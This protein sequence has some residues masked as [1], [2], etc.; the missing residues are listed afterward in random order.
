MKER[1][2]KNDFIWIERSGE[3]EQRGGTGVGFNSGVRLEIL[4]SCFLSVSRRN[5]HEIS[6]LKKKECVC[7]FAVLAQSLD[8]FQIWIVFT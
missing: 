8:H 5:G 3:G 1:E 7:A 4:Q 6:G 2:K